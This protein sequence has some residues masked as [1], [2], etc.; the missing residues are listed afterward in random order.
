[1]PIE[2]DM[3][4]LDPVK[5]LLCIHCLYLL[6]KYMTSKNVDPDDIIQE[7]ILRQNDAVPSSTFCSTDYYQKLYRH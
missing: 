6:L 2:D 5:H 3:S 4:F 1:M 7:V